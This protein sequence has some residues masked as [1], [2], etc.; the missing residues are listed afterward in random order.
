[1]AKREYTRYQKKVISRFYENRDQIDEQRLSELVTS[2]YLAANDTQ[3][4]RL[5]KQA[6][7]TMTR[8]KVPEGRVKHVVEKQDPAILAEVVK[9]V[10]SGVIPPSK[11][12]GK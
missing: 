1:M 12:A 3:K 9:D 8:M 6:E 11:P 10:Q 7:E 2:L 5:W 4:L